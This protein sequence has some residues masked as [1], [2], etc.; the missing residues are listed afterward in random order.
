MKYFL[1]IV[2]GSCLLE[3]VTSPLRGYCS[4][5]L[6]SVVAFIL[7]FLL[8]NVLCRK[9]AA[10]LKAEYIFI[11]AL[12]GC[13]LLQMPLRLWLPDTL[14]S[15][16][17]FLF[18]LLGIIMGYLFYK[19]TKIG[20]T[21]VL[22]ISLASCLFLYFKG[23]DM[24]MHKL[25]F[26]TVTG[27]IEMFT[28]PDFQFSDEQGSM[29]SIKDFSGKYVVVDFWYTGCGVCFEEFPFVQDLYDKYKNYP[30]VSIFSINAKIKR[31]TERAAFITLQKRGYSFPVYRLEMEDPILKQMGVNGYPTV[32]IF[33]KQGNV[34]FRGDIEN[35]A[36]YLL[37][38]LNQ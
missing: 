13:S 2:I 1:K 7:F 22:T 37:E 15:L 11:S 28:P 38:L 30:S 16:P 10:K 18:H 5:A 33:D 17:D 27:R 6:C 25:N 29:Y 31:D 8:V 24:W 19:S 21:V 32:L 36:K 3:L 23:Y 9:Y 14:I 20:K 26:G 34:I 4:F 12:I 35:V